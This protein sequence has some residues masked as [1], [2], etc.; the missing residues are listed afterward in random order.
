MRQW[1]SQTTFEKPG[2]GV[3][4][5]VGVAV[6]VLGMMIATANKNGRCYRRSQ[7]YHAS[8]SSSLSSRGDDHHGAR[9]SPLRTRMR[10][11]TAWSTLC[12]FFE[13][14]S[15]QRS[16][17][18][19]DPNVA[20]TSESKQP[21]HHASEWSAMPYTP[22]NSRF[23]NTDGSIPFRAWRSDPARPPLTGQAAKCDGAQQSQQKTQPE[24][25]AIIRIATESHHGEE[26]TP[27]T[28]DHFRYLSTGSASAATVAVDHDIDDG[29]ATK[30]ATAAAAIARWEFDFCRRSNRNFR[31]DDRCGHWW[32]DSTTGSE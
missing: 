32:D 9:V 23:Q 16:R 8:S 27:A 26:P 19:M 21:K 2:R 6:A 15:Q 30:T 25:A 28:T 10:N 4:E 31:D 24:A 17:R 13:S 12:G 22:P 14:A 20:T 7:Q 3:V 1:Y 29:G 18:M 11:E 5:I